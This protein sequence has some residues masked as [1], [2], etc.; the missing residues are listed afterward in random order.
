MLDILR[1]HATSWI[2]KAMLGAIIVSFALFFGYSAVRKSAGKG[3][4]AKAAAVVDGVPVPTNV[5]GYFFNANYERLKESMAKDKPVPDFVEQMAKS[6]AFEQAVSRQVAL[7][8]ANKL[9]VVIPDVMLASAIK[10][11]Q[12]GMNGGEFDPLFYKQR[13]LPHFKNKFGLDYEQFMRENLS[14]D[15]LRDIFVDVDKSEVLTDS[16]DKTLWTFEV[17]EFESKDKDK[18]EKITS[19][20]PKNWGDFAKSNGGKVTTVGPI[21]VLEHSKFP[22]ANVPFDD[23]IKIFSLSDSSPV[24]EKVIENAGKFYDVRLVS[25][26]KDAKEKLSPPDSENFYAAWMMRLFS[27]AKIKNMIEEPKPSAN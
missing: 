18:A 6:Y 21:T 14:L 24:L 16:P 12:V 7:N 15:A 13:F 5:F 17:V 23:L 25:V 10:D 19:E 2:I 11:M 9:G 3:N 20:S 4:M 22:F 1:K 8:E 26:K 27:N